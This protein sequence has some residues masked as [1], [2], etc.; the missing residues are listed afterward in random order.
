[1]GI[2]ASSDLLNKKLNNLEPKIEY[3]G[4]HL[5]FN[6]NGAE[7]DTKSIKYEFQDIS[8]TI[9]TLTLYS[10]EEISFRLP[11]KRT[12]KDL[13]KLSDVWKKYVIFTS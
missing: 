10:Y 2:L 11:F 7:S 12:A 3:L 8:G 1:M 13:R 6:S 4:L 9:S 5:L